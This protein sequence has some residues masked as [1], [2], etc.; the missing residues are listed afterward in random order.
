MPNPVQFVRRRPFITVSIVVVVAALAFGVWRV[1][2]YQPAPQYL[3]AAV[4]RMDIEESVLATG[5]IR[6]SQ[7]VAVGARV[8]GQVKSL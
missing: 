2:F 5:V 7:Q 3:T 6:P 1:A 8:S 4:A